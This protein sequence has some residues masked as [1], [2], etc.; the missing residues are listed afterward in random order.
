MDLDRCDTVLKD[1]GQPAYRAR[2]IK[3]AVYRDLAQGYEDIPTIPRPLRQELA[4]RMPFDELRLET[5]R[6]SPDG[7]TKNLFLTQDGLAIESV[8]IP[9][10]SGSRTVCVSTEAGCQIGCTF[11]AT[12]H[13]GF[14]RALTP[15]EIADQVLF[16][17]R[18]LKATS[19]KV[20]N[21]VFMGMGE[22]FLNY[23]HVRR[24]IL[25]LNDPDGLGLGQRR[26]SVST[27]GIVPGIE[28]FTEEGWQVNLAISL[29]APTDAL[30]SRLMPI[31]QTYPLDKLMP[32]LDHYV[33]ATNRRLMLEYL[34]LG[35]VNDAPDQALQLADLLRAWP[36][37][38]RLGLVNLMTYNPTRDAYGHWDAFKGPTERTLATFEET[39]TARGIPWT[40]RVSFGSDVGAACGQLAGEATSPRNT[41]L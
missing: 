20:S 3:L 14:Q 10:E 37:V 28:R 39:L 21:V 17:A 4:A 29:H 32:A 11:C 5:S 41:K 7:A 12:G 18:Q 2:Q 35:G 30:R 24:A 1:L 36:N 26:I 6:R 40:R 16:F 13:L 33:D 22:P 25:L 19:E 9:H 8:L 27:S 38:S 34:L 23:E 31:N 15:F